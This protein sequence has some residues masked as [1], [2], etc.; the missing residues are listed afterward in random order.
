[1]APSVFDQD[2]VL[3]TMETPLGKVPRVGFDLSMADRVGGCKV[4]WGIGRYDYTVVPGIY[5]LGDPD[6]D[7]PVL[8][9]ANYKLSFDALRREL[10]GLD[11]WLLPINTNGINVWCAAGKRTFGTDTLV[12]ALRETDLGRLVN[13]RRL[14]LPQ[15]GAPGVAAHEVK[16]QTGFEVKWGPV[17]STDIPAFF[18]HGGKV[19]PGMRL[20]E[21][22]MG[23]RAVLAPMELVPALKYGVPLGIAIV[24]LAGLL[25]GG[26]FV[27][28]ALGPGLFL[29]GAIL[30]AAVAGSV[31]G[32]MLL[33][34]LPGR[35]FSAKGAGLGLAAAAL[36][37]ALWQAEP[38]LAWSGFLI[39]AAMCSFVLMNFTGSST[40]T[41]LS[42][43]KK[44]MRIAVPMQIVGAV[45][46]LVLWL[47]ALLT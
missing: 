34:W 12:R 46:A 15:L 37:L 6:E 3:G 25:G 14:I 11:A 2:F 23:Q 9:T 28:S 27:E 30:W 20:M 10:V 24:L 5:A 42:G 1:L 33:P 40:F 29:A 17:R 22:P 19:Q 43:V 7:S 32:P 44:E 39:I 36:Y 21:F 47:W 35:A 31:A 38:L 8:V 16:R 26:Y 13:H 45:L 18:D 4:R 41:S